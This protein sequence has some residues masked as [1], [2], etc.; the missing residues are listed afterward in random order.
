M[1]FG[2]EHFAQ[3]AVPTAQVSGTTNLCAGGSGIIQATLTGTAPWNL[4]WSDGFTQ[5]GIASSPAVRTVSPSVTTIYQVLSVSDAGN[6]SGLSSGEAVVRVFQTP[7]ITSQ[8]ADA[9][10][11]S[12]STATFS[13]VANGAPSGV[14][15]PSAVVASTSAKKTSCACMAALIPGLE[16]DTIPSWTSR[17]VAGLA[18]T[19]N[20]ITSYTYAVIGPPGEGTNPVS[21][22][23]GPSAGSV[24]GTSGGTTSHIFTVTAP[25]GKE[26]D[27]ILVKPKKQ[28]TRAD[29]A[30]HHQKIGA[31][32]K[33][34]FSHFGNLQVVKLPPGL[35]VANAIKQ[36]QDSGLVD[37]AEPDYQVHAVLSPNDPRY[38]DGSLWNLNSISAPA[39]WDIRTSADPIIVAVIDTGVWYSHG[40]LA[41]NMWVNPCVG[42]PVDGVVYPNDVHG[43]NAITGTGDPLDDMFHGTHCAG[44]IGAVGNNGIGGV[45][46]AWN[47]RIMACKFLDANGS[48]NTSDAIECINYAL[49]KGAKVLSCSW[50]GSPYDPAL[51]DAIA[52]ARADDVILVAAAGNNAANNDASPFYP[53]S[54][55]SDL[56]NVVTVAATDWADQ[57]AYFSDYGAASVALGA[58]GVN[59]FSTLPSIETAAMQN[60]GLTPNYGVLSGTSMACP[61][62]AGVVAMVCAQ[63]PAESH[64]QIIQR[65]LSN[66]D[67]VTDLSGRTLTGG[68]LNL[69]NALAQPPQPPFWLTYQW[70]MNGTNIP[71][72]TGSSYSFGPVTTNDNGD[73]FDVVISNSCGTVLSTTAVL[74]VDTPCLITEQPTSM[75]PHVGDPAI[76]SVSASGS[77]PLN[78]R[79]RKIGGGWSRP[80][81]LTE[82][83]PGSGSL[84]IGSST[85]N[86]DRTYNPSY[87]TDVDVSGKAF[88]INASGEHKMQ[89][90]RSLIEPL[91]PGGMFTISMDNGYVGP[92]SA[93]GF[94]MYSVSNKLW[95]EFYC[96]NNTYYYSAYGVAPRLATWI[97]FTSHGINLFFDMFPD[98]TLIVV[99]NVNA[100]SGST[101][102]NVSLPAM[103]NDPPDHFTVY[104]NSA[105]DGPANDIY[106][107][108]LGAYERYDLGAL[109]GYDDATQTAYTNGWQSG[110]DGGTGPIPGATNGAYVISSCTLMDSGTYNLILDNPCDFLVS[111]NTQLTVLPTINVLDHFTWN[112][113]SSPRYVNTPFAVTIQARD[114]TNSIFTNFTGTVSLGFTNGIAVTPPVS[115]NFVQGVWTGSVVIAQTASNLVLQADDGFGHFGLANPIDVLNLPNL[116]MMHYGNIAL[117][118]WP[119]GYSDF[120]LEAS[121]SLSPATWVTV[122]YAPIQIGDQYLYLLQL[123]M[124]DTNGFYRLQFPGP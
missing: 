89:L 56:D 18:R 35:T 124:T 81:V 36:Y 77:T 106:F 44:I 82:N 52:A 60:Y 16:G 85:N 51:H 114:L 91:P 19:S 20:G 120:V 28:I 5:P 71:D 111:S 7:A 55:D 96:T 88:G 38:L 118:V 69:F 64:S 68:R 26:A 23:L 94:A 2:P 30:A 115:G 79:W 80:W 75:T 42:C 4:V 110:D 9:T 90:A 39:G 53:A 24:A 103:K 58:P 119:V 61:H 49:N 31:T 10:L 112:P 97:P 92:K 34:T 54:Y 15:G 57:L 37:Y 25:L 123:D 116:G 6:A 63:Y 72:Q 101:L 98:G 62:V 121:S 1:L 8:P 102:F 104:N 66:T 76:F 70:R 99:A 109:V 67:P 93:A 43:I 86:G 108:N 40:D 33:R 95:F 113:V 105:G 29:L 12:G 11:C 41:S 84:F 32:V 122:P 117:L 65:L 100:P 73:H 50:G 14:N 27:T 87:P 78:Y 48:G 3:A 22:W 13:V 45:G 74:T 17:S 47:V 46:V 59:I 107:N 83:G 21:S